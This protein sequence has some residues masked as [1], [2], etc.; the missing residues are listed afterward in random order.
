M[1]TITLMW[2]PPRLSNGVISNYIVLCLFNHNVINRTVTTSTKLTIVG[3][4]QFTNYTCSVRAATLFG[5]GPPIVKSIVTD[6]G[7]IFVWIVTLHQLYVVFVVY[8]ISF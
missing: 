3:L 4:K 6:K 2:S 1:H 5:T 7:I 8:F